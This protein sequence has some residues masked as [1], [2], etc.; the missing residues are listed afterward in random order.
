M[1]KK[2]YV[3]LMPG[4]SEHFAAGTCGVGRRVLVRHTIIR[5]WAVLCRTARL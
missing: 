5:Q 2:R 3:S 4:L 1:Y